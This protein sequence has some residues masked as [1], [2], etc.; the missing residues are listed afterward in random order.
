M[1]DNRTNREMLIQLETEI[2]NLKVGFENHLKHHEKIW[3]L[4]CTAALSGVVN[5]ILLLVR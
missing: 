1:S 4:L 3:Y 2:V 5:L